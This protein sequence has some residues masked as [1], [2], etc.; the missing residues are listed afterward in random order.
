MAH[1]GHTAV[2]AADT[3]GTHAARVAPPL[4]AESQEAKPDT[5]AEI[6]HAQRVRGTVTE[7]GGAHR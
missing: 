5:E 4:L 2:L 7:G 3:E 1:P 6:G